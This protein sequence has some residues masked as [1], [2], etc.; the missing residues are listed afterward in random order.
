MYTGSTLLVRAD[1]Q[2]IQRVIVKGNLSAANLSSVTYPARNFTISSNASEAYT[3]NV[4][5][6]YPS[7]YTTSLSVKDQSGKP[8]G[9]LPSYYV[10]NG[11]LNLTIIANFQTS[12]STG[13]GA[14]LGLSSLYEW[15]V[16][17]GGAFPVWV[18][19]L[20]LV[21]G[22]QFAF[23]GF[24]WVKFEDERRRIEGHLPPLD[25]GNKAYLWTDIA[26]KTLITGFAIS[27]ALMVGE[28]LIIFIA[29][30]LL[31]INLNL[32]SLID[33]FSLFFVAVVAAIVYLAR[34]GLDRLLDLKPMMED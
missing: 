25:K 5:L 22:V 15:M 10:S 13:T 34:E 32:I 29:Q 33:F 2:A 28:A 30:Y 14:P 27:L 24:R 16:Q 11:D 23:V 19:V 21:I 6:S 26:F 8:S 31:L 4:Y 1:Q 3:L 9:Q 20:Y 18:K 7:A 17:F 12:P